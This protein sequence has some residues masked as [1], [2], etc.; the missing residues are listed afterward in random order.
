VKAIEVSPAELTRCLAA[1]ANAE[2][3]ELFIGVD[4]DRSKDS[5]PAGL[6]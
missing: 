6:Y 3:G 4:E 2:G 1:F 5:L